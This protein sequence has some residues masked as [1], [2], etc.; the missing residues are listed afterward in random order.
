[1]AH[2]L[3]WDGRKHSAS[4]V[5]TKRQSLQMNSAPIQ[6][7]P[8]FDAAAPARDGVALEQQAELD[9]NGVWL[10]NH[11]PHGRVRQVGDYA[12]PHR[13]SVVKADP[14][15]DSE[16]RGASLPRPLSVWQP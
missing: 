15:P 8:P 6:A 10:V 9:G 7:A 13:E 16:L 11:D 3:A 5:P 12:R 4:R 1:M 14:G 2:L